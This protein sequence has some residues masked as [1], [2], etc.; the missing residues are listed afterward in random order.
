LFEEL[1]KLG[2]KLKGVGEPK[3]HLG[4]DYIQRKF[5]H[6]R[7]VLISRKS[8]LSMKLFS[9]NWYKGRDFMHHCS[10]EIIQS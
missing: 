9:R 10:L 4:G 2:Y 8:Y 3:Y 5:L 7:L 6:E 1:E